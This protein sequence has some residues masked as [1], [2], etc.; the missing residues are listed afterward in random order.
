MLKVIKAELKK[1]VSKPGIFILA[2]FLA[3]ILVLGVFLYHPEVRKYDIDQHSY[4]IFQF[5]T[6]GN[7]KE[8][9]DTQLANTTKA[10]SSYFIQEDDAKISYYVK[11]YGEDGNGGLWKRY[12][13]TCK[14]MQVKASE[15]N[16]QDFVDEFLK[17]L[18]EIDRKSVV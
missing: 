3:V 7:D 8:Q 18:N 16:A 4:E 17:V 1:M 9:A 2:I 14:D 6:P 13:E 15:S 10:V 12:N 5:E 11:M